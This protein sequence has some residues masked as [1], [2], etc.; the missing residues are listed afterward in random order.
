GIGQP[1][2]WSREDRGDD[3]QSGGSLLRGEGCAAAAEQS[4]L[5]A[6]G[7]REAVDALLHRG[8]ED[9]RGRCHMADG[10]RAIAANDAALGL[11][12]LQVG[13]AVEGNTFPVE[14]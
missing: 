6:R 5:Q 7:T 10:I 11:A 13:A 12:S 2:N 9:Q 3:P 14:Q 8:L 4:R 1:R